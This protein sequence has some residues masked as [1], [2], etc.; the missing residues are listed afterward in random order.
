V[1]DPD[2]PTCLDAV[3]D[4]TVGSTP[5]HNVTLSFTAGPKTQAVRVSVWRSRSRV[6]PMEISGTFWVDA[7]SV[8]AEQH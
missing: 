3:T 4:T 7:V 5:W 8:R 1:T 2:C 6:F